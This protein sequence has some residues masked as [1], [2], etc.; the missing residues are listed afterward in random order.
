MPCPTCDHSMHKFEAPEPTWWCP[1]CGTLMSHRPH[2]GKTYRV[3]QPPALVERVRA[4]VRMASGNRELLQAL[5]T[6]GILEASYLPG[7]RPHV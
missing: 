6:L 3:A 4:A 1:R 7:D 5:H 2:M